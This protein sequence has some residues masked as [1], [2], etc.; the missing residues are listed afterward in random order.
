MSEVQQER[1]GMRTSP[2]IHASS[3]R[4][5][6]AAFVLS[7]SKKFKKGPMTPARSIVMIAPTLLRLEGHAAGLLLTCRT[8]RRPTRTASIMQTRY[9][10]SSQTTDLSIL[11]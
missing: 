8:I 3:T 1:P 6:I 2:A 5:S 7:L 9:V 4:A 11:R 10:D